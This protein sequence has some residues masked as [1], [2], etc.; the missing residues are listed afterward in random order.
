[1]LDTRQPRS[2]VGYFADDLWGCATLNTPHYDFEGSVA[3]ARGDDT[4]E[5][6]SESNIKLILKRSSLSTALD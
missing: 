4:V 6:V 3:R 1:M 2:Q 5:I